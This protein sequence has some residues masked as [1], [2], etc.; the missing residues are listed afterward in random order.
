M[1]QSVNPTP[2]PIPQPNTAPPTPQNKNKKTTVIIVILLVILAIG[3]YISYSK[4]QARRATQKLFEN[5]GMNPQAAAI[6]GQLAD[7]VDEQNKPSTP[8]EIFKAAETIEIIDSK[9]KTE[10]E[11]LGG[12]IK[13]ALGDYKITGFTSGYMGMNSG[14]CV[15]EYTLAKILS[16]N[17]INTIS[18]ELENLGMKVVSVMQQDDSATLMAQKGNNAYTVS[19]NKDEQEIMAVVLAGQTPN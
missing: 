5:M 16:L 9:Q 4:W 3:A 18:K 13:A 14:S 10:A 17:D 7:E 15:V 19:F 12:A 2:T 8:E 11:E 6:L 1:E